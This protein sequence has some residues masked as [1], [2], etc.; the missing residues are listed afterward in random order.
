MPRSGV[1]SIPHG[2]ILRYEEIL[3]VIEAARALGFRRFRITGGAP[4]V[5]RG[6]LW[7]LR[8]LNR[9][10]ISYTMTTNGL[11]LSRFV[12]E[13]RDA[14]IERINV[15]LDTLG[16]RT[17]RDITGMDGLDDVLRGIEAARGAGIAAV[18]VNV[19][20][21]RGVNEGEVGGFID[22]GRRERLDIRFIEF[23]PV[24]GEDL[25]LPLK[26]FIDSLER[27]QRYKRV[28][29]AGGGPA[30][31]FRDTETGSTVG[32]I[33]P[34][35]APFCTACN[36]LRLTADGTL[37]PCL[38]SS[39]GIDLRGPLR[40]GENI[41]ELI[42]LAVRSKPEGHKLNMKLHRYGMHALGG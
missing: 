18:K 29:D 4:L 22:W 42:S 25:Y 13:L 10:R 16:R 28:T 21:M 38:F 31:C 23:M 19:V 37:L 17:F 24:C 33:L 9:Q 7:F 15:G 35:T 27:Q 8:E 32:F 5:R 36:R 12:G 2:E 39:D 14:G 34:R 20:V 26:P 6:V 40:R 1:R 30:Q 41:S 3:T 11:L